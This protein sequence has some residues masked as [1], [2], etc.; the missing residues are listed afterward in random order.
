ML[1]IA[2]VILLTTV[3]GVP[4]GI[5]GLLSF[6]ALFVYSWIVTPI[7]VGSFVHKWVMKT[8]MYSVT[9]VTILI[10]VVVYVIL[11][12]IPFLGWIVRFVA[13]LM[14]IGAVVRIKWDIIKEWR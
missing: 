14:T 4:F 2:S 10:G 1:P 12:L 13:A 11:G 9:W 7:V 8:P 5:L 6:A 3:V